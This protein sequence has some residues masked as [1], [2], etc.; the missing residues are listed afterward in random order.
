MPPEFEVAVVGAGIVGA[1]C[2]WECARAGLNV[3]LIEPG[4]TGGGAT[5]A[6]MGQLVVEDGSEPEFRLTQYSLRLWG[7][8]QPELPAAAEFDRVGSIWVAS[9]EAEMREL[10]RKQQSYARR[11]VAA[12][13]LR[14]EELAALEPRLRPGLSGGMLTPEDVVLYPPPACD[15]LVDRA[16]ALGARVFRGHAAKNLERSTVRLTNGST[17][18]A[19]SIVNAAGT[20]SPTLSPGVPVRPR[21]GQLAMTDRYPGW[22]HHQLVEMGYVQRAASGAAESVSFNLQPRRNGQ[23]LIGS[24]R[25]LGN[26]DPH[27]DPIFL[28]SMLSRAMEF[29][30]GLAELSVIRT[31]TG[32]RPASSDHLPLIG[33]WPLQEGVFLATGHDG[34]GV[35]MALGTGRLLADQVVGRTAAIPVEPYLPARVLPGDHGP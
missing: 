24:S 20:A 26:D 31:W 27:V 34:L 13:L 25:Q 9:D 21:K 29:V 33:P 6:N 28:R 11:E 16:R 23:L 18:T 10:E 1:S 5:A 32:F 15:F 35:T 22:I 19:R 7:D 2:A 12:T 14:R 30:P 8:L 4:L 3:A 17:V